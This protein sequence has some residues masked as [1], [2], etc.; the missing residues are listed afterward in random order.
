MG[1][2]LKKTIVITGAS[3][4][5]G[6]AGARTLVEQG[7]H[8]VIV[9]RSPQKTAAVANELSVPHYLA[10]FATLADV[11]RL[12]DQLRRDFA[13]I[14]VLANNAGGIM[15]AHSLTVDGNELTTQVN[16]LAPFLLTT[17]LLDTLLESQAVVVT[18]ASSAHR[19]ARIDLGDME[20]ASHYS[21]FRAYARAKLMNILFAKELHRRY[22]SRGIRSAA[23]HPGVV[24]SNFSSEFGGLMNLGFSSAARHF[25][26]TPA[27][28]ADTM[29]WLATTDDW[30]GGQ[31]FKDRHVARAS[32]QADDREL[33]GALWEISTSLTSAT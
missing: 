17:V 32:K 2:T 18:T 28:G 15:G 23:F 12:A 27:R 7:H 24:K 31:Y 1:M 20:Y 11:R 22:E 29:V 3:D 6:A 33:A 9:G 13:T 8:V 16:H 4:G 25:F 21:A 10:D 5:V 30:P 26:R 19:T 14:D